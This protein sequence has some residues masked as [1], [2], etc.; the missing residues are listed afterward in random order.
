MVISVALYNARTATE[1]NAKVALHANN[2]AL[3][4]SAGVPRGAVQE[5]HEPKRDKREDRVTDLE[6]QW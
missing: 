6:D 4:T 3:S 5:K 2:N 1:K